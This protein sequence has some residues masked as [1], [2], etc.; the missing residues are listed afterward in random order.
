VQVLKV[1]EAADY[2]GISKSTLDKLRCHGGGPLYFKIGKRVVYDR[3]DL[4]TW[5]ANKRVANTAAAAAD[6]YRQEDYNVRPQ[7]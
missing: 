4:D 3:A 7:Q 6:T 2:C 1:A 5:L